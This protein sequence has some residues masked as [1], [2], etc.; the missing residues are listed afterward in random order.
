MARMEEKAQWMLNRFIVMK[1]EEKRMAREAQPWCLA[2][3]CRDLGDAECCRSEIVREIGA[4]K[5]PVIQN[6][7][8]G[9][10]RLRNLNDEM[11]VLKRL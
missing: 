7:G 6:E 11:K 4:K 3:E 10:H 8:L 5:V 1:R 2:N 9:E